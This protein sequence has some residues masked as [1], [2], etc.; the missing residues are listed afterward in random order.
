MAIWWGLVNSVQLKDQTVSPA[1]TTLNYLPT[2]LA[3]PAM[4]DLELALKLAQITERAS[5]AKVIVYHV[6]TT[7]DLQVDVEPIFHLPAVE[8]TE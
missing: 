8:P 3:N 4:K 1:P 2:C 6:S 5:P 7:R